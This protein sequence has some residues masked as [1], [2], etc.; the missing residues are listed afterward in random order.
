MF[1]CW[2]KINVTQ[3]KG[4]GL[5]HMP[6]YRSSQVKK[7]VLVAHEK[8]APWSKVGNDLFMLAGKTACFTHLFSS[9]LQLSPGKGNQ[10]GNF[11]CHIFLL[12]MFVGAGCVS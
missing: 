7:P 10:P 1:L 8:L 3:R 6:Q 5:V 2:P 9:Y 4:E 11:A 12:V